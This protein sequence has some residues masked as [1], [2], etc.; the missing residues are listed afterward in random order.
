MAKG[1]KNDHQSE[2]NKLPLVRN[3][4]YST[5]GISLVVVT[6]L[7]YWAVQQLKGIPAWAWILEAVGI[8]LVLSFA[9][10]QKLPRPYYGLLAAVSLGWIWF[11]TGLIVYL[12]L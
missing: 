7:A 12:G 5:A 10:L 8:M 6:L 4:V 2:R 1:I 3:A 11:A 9:N